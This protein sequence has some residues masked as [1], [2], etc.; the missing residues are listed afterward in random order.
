MFK[1]AY[2]LAIEWRTNLQQLRDGNACDESRGAWADQDKVVEDDRADGSVGPA[3]SSDQG[4]RA[5][6]HL[7]ERCGLRICRVGA[8]QSQDIPR[9]IRTKVFAANGPTGCALDFRASLCRNAPDSARPLPYQLRLATDRGGNSGLPASALIDVF[10]E[11][12]GGHLKRAASFNQAQRLLPLL[13]TALAIEPMKTVGQIRVDN[14]A[15]LVKENGTLEAV[16]ELAGTSSVYLS[17]IR[18]ASLDQ[19]TGRPRQMGTPMARR[20]EAA[21]NK[22]LGWMDTP[23]AAEDASTEAAPS[24]IVRA[25]QWPFEQLDREKLGKLS[26]NDAL[27]LEGAIL[28]A[29][30]QLGLDVARPDSGKRRSA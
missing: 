1:S 29:A 12:H 3:D 18:N 21:C 19:S 28:T 27:R 2:A 5:G 22:P 7:R 11:V 25:A 14:V 6:G 20:L 10:G 16:A 15:L 9:D 26:H 30:A 23:H 24:N 4:E 8:L 17:Q 13:S